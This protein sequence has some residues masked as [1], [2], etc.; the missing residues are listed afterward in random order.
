M[1]LTIASV[2]ASRVRRAPEL[3]AGIVSVTIG[4]LRKNPPINLVD[5]SA[6]KGL[7]MI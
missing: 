7:V 3:K 4:Q 1:T 5:A 6:E 2:N